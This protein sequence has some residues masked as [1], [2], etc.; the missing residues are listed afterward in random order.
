[1]VDLSLQQY[2]NFPNVGSLII[3]VE[4]GIE[5]DINCVITFVYYNIVFSLKCITKNIHPLKLRLALLY[6][7]YKNN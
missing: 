5:V 3:L 2:D 1:M 7:L 6:E 4:N